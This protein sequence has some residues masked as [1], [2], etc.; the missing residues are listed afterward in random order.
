MHA[1]ALL[2]GQKLSACISACMH[3]GCMHAHAMNAG[4]QVVRRY[5]RQRSPARTVIDASG[6]LPEGGGAEAGRVSVERRTA[7]TD[8]SATGISEDSL[9]A[10]STLLPRAW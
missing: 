10:L 5:V 1:R 8:R 4:A 2:V 7:V 9:A 3:A 6:A